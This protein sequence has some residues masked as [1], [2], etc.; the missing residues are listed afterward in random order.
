MDKKYW[1]ALSSIEKIDS[2]FIQKLYDHFGD[3]ETAFNCDINDFK[4]IT[5]VTKNAVYNFLQERDK[6]DPDKKLEKVLN[7]GIKFITLADEN[8]PYMLKNIS[9]P[10]AV[11]YYKGDFARCNLEKTLAVVGSRKASPTGKQVLKKL[12]GELQGTDLTVVSGLAS[13][14]DTVAHQSAIESN[15]KTIGVIASG[16]DYIYP[17][18]NK[19]LYEQIENEHGVVISEYYP[20]F[21]PLPYRFPQRNRIVTGLSYGTL[22]VEAALKSGALISA[23]LTLEQGRELMCIPGSINNPNTAGIYKLLKNGATLVTEATDILNALDWELKKVEA[24]KVGKTE[25]GDNLTI[26][27]GLIIN[28][29]EKEIETFD[30]IQK[31]TG[32]STDELLS[33]LTI[34]EIKG[35]INQVE[36]DRYTIN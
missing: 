11:I 10:P 22:V 32:I 30:T 23:N 27:E 9:N 31:E 14:I 25:F 17:K 7:K 36:G 2:K 33:C 6:T 18:E 35:I 20:T 34:L 21:E 4:E 28:A 5:N 12:I 19:K 29:I 13:G 16:F 3:I 15:L 26:T 8:Y 1:I 24:Q